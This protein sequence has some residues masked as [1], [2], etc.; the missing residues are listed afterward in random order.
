[1]RRDNAGDT[2]A[3][4]S[5]PAFVINM[6]AWLIIVITTGLQ[7]MRRR[8]PV[9]ESSNNRITLKYLLSSLTQ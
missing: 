2:V 6:V 9:L 5:A 1:M 8:M 4:E 7:A 3:T